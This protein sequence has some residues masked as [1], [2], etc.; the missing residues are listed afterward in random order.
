MQHLFAYDWIPSFGIQYLMGI[1]GISFPLVVLTAFVSHAGDGRQL[2]DHEAREGL[3]RAV[4]AA[5]D[6][7]DRRVS[8]RSISSCSTCSG[9]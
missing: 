5:R 3:L 9:K 8:A 4:P 2:A 7:H 1:D 6:G